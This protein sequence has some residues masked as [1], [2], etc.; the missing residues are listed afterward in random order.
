MQFFGFTAEITN[1][2]QTKK[3]SGFFKI[4]KSKVSVPLFFSF[5]NNKAP[6][7]AQE[8][9]MFILTERTRFIALQTNH[10]SRKPHVYEETEYYFHCY[11]KRSLER[12]SE[13]HKSIVLS[14]LN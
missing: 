6:P 4:R 13:L 11:Y 5:M 9:Q 10:L 8:T 7:V 3:F 12:R 2:Y 1:I 14:D